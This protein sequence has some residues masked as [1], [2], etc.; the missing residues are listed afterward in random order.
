MS[1]LPKLRLKMPDGQEE[2]HGFEEAKT[3]LSDWGV[4]FVV[5]G[6]VISSYEELIELADQSS[7][8]DKEPLEVMLIPSIE[9]G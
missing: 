6:Q 3:Y 1:K 7:Y 2:V 8:K 5:E 9:G 4:L